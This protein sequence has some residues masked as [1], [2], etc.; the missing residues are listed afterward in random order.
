MEWEG[1]LKGMTKIWALMKVWEQAPVCE[2]GNIWTNGELYG[3]QEFKEM[4]ASL[5]A[6]DV[7]N[8]KWPQGL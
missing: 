2:S 7:I 6:T 4:W 3:V 5:E 8:V 1:G